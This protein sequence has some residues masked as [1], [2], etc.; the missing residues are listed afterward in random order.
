MMTKRD[1]DFERALCDIAAVSPGSSAGDCSLPGDVLRQVALEPPAGKPTKNATGTHRDRIRDR[2]PSLSCR[3]LDSEKPYKQHDPWQ[4]HSN[5]ELERLPSRASLDDPKNPCNSLTASKDSTSFCGSKVSTPLSEPK[6]SP[7]V[8][9]A[10]DTDDL[11]VIHTSLPGLSPLEIESP[12]LDQLPELGAA[13]GPVEDD[14][15]DVGYPRAH[16][17]GRRESEPVLSRRNLP[18]GGQRRVSVSYK[19]YSALSLCFVE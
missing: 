16:R 18:D 3:N 2:V 8:E 15:R 1:P 19:L 14:Y 6:D 5:L 4:T 11:S 12:V 17:R 10:G 9:A 7:S 13:S